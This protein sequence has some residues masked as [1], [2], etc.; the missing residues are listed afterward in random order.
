MNSRYINNM[1]CIDIFKQDMNY[2]YLNDR[3]HH[4]TLQPQLYILWLRWCSSHVWWPE[5]VSINITLFS[6]EYLINVPSSSHDHPYQH[7]KA[8]QAVSNYMKP[9]QTIRN[10]FKPYVKLSRT[11]SKQYNVGKRTINHPSVITIDSWYVQHSQSWVGYGI[12]IPLL[13]GTMSNYTMSN[14]TKS[15]KTICLTV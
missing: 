11:I 13:K 10:H 1:C 4:G 9:Y 15:K 2:R 6:V 14:Y 12:V 8:A 7:Y 5:D 3:Y